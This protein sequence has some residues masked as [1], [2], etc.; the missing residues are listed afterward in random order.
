MQ[1]G[2]ASVSF[3]RLMH[4]LFRHSKTASLRRPTLLLAIFG[5]LYVLSTSA[6]GGPHR[7]YS[8]EFGLLKFG[9]RKG[10]NETDMVQSF[11]CTPESAITMQQPMEQQQARPSSTDSNGF[12]VKDPDAIKLF[13]GQVNF[14]S[15]I[16]NIKALD[17]EKSRRKRL[18][19]SF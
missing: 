9:L 18:T 11:Y 7:L 3:S 6:F 14:N 13:V 1:I 16:Y 4:M 5:R 12:P 15:H 10:C 17:S 2:V 19:P 8:S